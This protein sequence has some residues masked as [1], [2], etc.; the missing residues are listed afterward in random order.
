MRF[1]ALAVLLCLVAPSVSRIACGWECITERV[2][3]PLATCHEDSAGGAATGGADRMMRAVVT[4]CHEDRTPSLTRVAISLPTSAPLADDGVL[5][6][7]RL[8]PSI[9][10]VATVNT[11]ASPAVHIRSIQLRI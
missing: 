1:A 10:D 11:S 4:T 5:F 6:E 7:D 9:R 3:T 8:G 2:A